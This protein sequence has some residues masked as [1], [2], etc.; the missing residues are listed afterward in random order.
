[1]NVTDTVLT[2]RWVNVGLALLLGRVPGLATGLGAGCDRPPATAIKPGSEYQFCPPE[3]DRVRRCS[4]TDSV[5][6]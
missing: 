5:G 6:R 1:M 2:L 4:P 3:T